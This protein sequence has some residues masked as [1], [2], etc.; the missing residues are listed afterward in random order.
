MTTCWWVGRACV[1]ACVCHGSICARCAVVPCSQADCGA[2]CVMRLV[3]HCAGAEEVHPG[4][5]DGV[6]RPE[7]AA[8]PGGKHLQSCSGML[9]TFHTLFATTVHLTKCSC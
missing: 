8:G 6:P 2:R 9:I 7:E 1:S 3:T 4:H 5:Q